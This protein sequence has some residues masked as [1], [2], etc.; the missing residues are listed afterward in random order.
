MVIH[1]NKH[2][3]FLCL[4]IFCHMAKE[5]T[6]ETVIQQPN[7]LD[8]TSESIT[9]DNPD[10]FSNNN[11]Q[12]VQNYSPSERLAQEYMKASSFRKTVEPNKRL[13]ALLIDLTVC[14]IISILI[15]AIVSVIPLLPNLLSQPIILLILFIFR[16]YFFG[17]R[18]VGKNLMGLK[19]VDALSGQPISLKQSF[20][21]NITFT[22]PLIVMELVALLP[23][24]VL[25]VLIRDILNILE[26]IYSLI[27]LPL[28]SYRAFSREDSLRIG[29][30]LAQTKIIQ[31]QTS[32]DE[33][34]PKKKN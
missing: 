17:G 27:F 15:S 6:K 12:N 19:V 8:N 13:I 21:R 25:P 33:F 11:P 30:T 18:G 26:T 28:E 7:P 29:D 31:T 34:V 24:A 32:F 22:A 9:G 23:A 1:T 16:D 14:Y 20:L 2:Y 10:N 4:R 3:L 5:P